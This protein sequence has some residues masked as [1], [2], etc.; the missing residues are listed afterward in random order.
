MN[1]PADVKVHGAGLLIIRM[2]EGSPW[3]LLG[4]RAHTFGESTWAQPGGRVR[5][6]ETPEQ[7][8]VRETREET[9]LLLQGITPIVEAPP[10]VLFC[11]EYRWVTH[12]FACSV[13]PQA[14]ATLCEPDKCSC[15]MFFPWDR[16]PASRFPS[17]K[18]LSQR[19]TRK[20][21]A[22]Y[23]LQSVAASM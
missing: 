3:V 2:I 17:L 14:C 5:P 12:H 16:L 11:D 15:W 6:D 18:Y 22:G 4:L 21:L 10:I 23:F 13:S 20:D 1:S 8:A 7:A 19:L 9:G